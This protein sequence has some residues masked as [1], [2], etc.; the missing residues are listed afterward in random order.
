MI[1]PN[2]LIILTSAECNQFCHSVQSYAAAQ[3]NGM[4]P[5]VQ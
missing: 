4:L 3:S 1:L 5:S 2:H